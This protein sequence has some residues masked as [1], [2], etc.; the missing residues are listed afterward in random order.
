MLGP[1]RIR[2]SVPSILCYNRSSLYTRRPLFV[3]GVATARE[4]PGVK[5]RVE[6]LG[7]FSTVLSRG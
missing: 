7:F 5:I 1:P 4:D 2:F 3:G 6:G